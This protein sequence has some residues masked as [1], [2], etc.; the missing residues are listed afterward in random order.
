PSSY[1]VYNERTKE[2]E[3]WTAS[4]LDHDQKFQQALALAPSPILTVGLIVI[5]VAIFLL[6]VVNG[7]PFFDPPADSL[8]RWG[9]DFG[10]LTTHGEWWRLITA[11]FVHIGLIHLAMNMYFQL[12]IVM[13]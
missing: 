13:F 8:L 1:I 3:V 11:A 12:S 5:N 6:M 2:N 7:V 9:A 4:E 10:P